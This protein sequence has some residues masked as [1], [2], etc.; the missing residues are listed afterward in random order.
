MVEMLDKKDFTCYFAGQQCL[1][2]ITEGWMLYY[3]V[4]AWSNVA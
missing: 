4:H 1:W 3:D 2:R